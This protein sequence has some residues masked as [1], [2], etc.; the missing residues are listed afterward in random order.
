MNPPSKKKKKDFKAEKLNF[1]VFITFLFWESI[2]L[3][4]SVL[5]SEFT[6]RQ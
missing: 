4:L 2:A 3:I 1:E 5:D 6:E